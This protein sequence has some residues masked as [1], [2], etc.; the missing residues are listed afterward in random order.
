MEQ[1]A[2]PETQEIVR[3]FEWSP[4]YDPY[5]VQP[6]G[7][8][9]VLSRGGGIA[10]R[11][12]VVVGGLMPAVAESWFPA[13]ENSYGIILE[14]DVEVSPMFYAWAKMNILRYKYVLVMLITNIDLQV[15]LQIW[16][17]SEQN[18]RVVRD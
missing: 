14:D 3:A 13:N 2:D 12:R 1:T 5:L 9:S 4:S 16:V 7:S 11:H 10:V 15:I 8:E 18:G 17:G 6:D